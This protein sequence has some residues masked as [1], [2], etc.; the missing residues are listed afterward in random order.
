M[1]KEFIGGF[2]ELVSRPLYFLPALLAGIINLF[3]M[4]AV[5]ENSFNFFMQTLVL[6][7]VP[8]VNLWQMPFY[9]IN[10]YGQDLIAMLLGTLASLAVGFY[11]LYVYSALIAAKEKGIV[12]AIAATAKKI[13]EILA[14]SVFVLAAFFIYST[15]AYF[16]FVAGVSIEAIGIIL[17]I[18]LL[19]WLVLGVYFFLMLA[20]TPLFMA[21]NGTKL[22]KALAESW[23]WSP[24][25]LL[26]IA[27]FLAV[28]WFLTMAVATLFS[29]ISDFA[30]SDELI[31]GTLMLGMAVSGAYYN[32]TF[33]KYFLANREKA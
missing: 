8:D 15:I 27:V 31:A 2:T 16:V 28:L 13:P 22:K 6:G 3:V 25:R 24:K 20:F 7:N 10:S 29:M 1:L 4:V 30:G 26:H 33:I 21:L 11:I 17:F 14:L 23:K 9:I 19:A 18:A 5:S 12:K 32:I